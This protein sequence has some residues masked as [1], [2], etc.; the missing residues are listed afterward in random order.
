MNLSI[1]ISLSLGSLPI[2]DRI[3]VPPPVLTTGG[4]SYESIFRA[5]LVGTGE[6]TLFKDVAGTDPVT[7]VGDLV[8]CWKSSVGSFTMTQATSTKR[9]T[10]QQRADGKYVVRFDGV[11]DELT[12]TLMTSGQTAFS[13]GSNHAWANPPTAFEGVWHVGPASV[14]VEATLINRGPGFNRIKIHRA[15]SADIFDPADFISPSSVVFRTQVGTSNLLVGTG[16][17]IA[18]TGSSI[19]VGAGTQYFGRSPAGSF[20]DCDIAAACFISGY[21]N[22]A[23]RTSLKTWLDSLLN[24]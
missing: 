6:N 24:I 12:G 16:S 13:C 10:L 2:P 4:A 11:D 3:P 9:P 18:G 17:S 5:D 19:A 15:S 8:A 14:D 23:D 1:G 21:I 20:G 7:A 22:D